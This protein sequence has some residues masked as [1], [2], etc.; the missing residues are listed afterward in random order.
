MTASVYEKYFGN[1]KA[2]VQGQAQLDPLSLS[3]PFYIQVSAAK[4][5]GLSVEEYRKKFNRKQRYVFHIH[6]IMEIEKEMHS[7]EKAQRERE[8]ASSSSR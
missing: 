3:T 8:S 6:R 4:G 1:S 7:Y 2:F 5:F